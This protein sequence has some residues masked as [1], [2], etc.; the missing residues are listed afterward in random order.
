VRDDRLLDGNL[1]R[2]FKSFH[3]G[4]YWTYQMH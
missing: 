3:R 4:S 1:A 2:V